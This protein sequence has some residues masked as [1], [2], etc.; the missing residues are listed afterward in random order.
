MRVI[1]AE[2]V[3]ALGWAAAIDAIRAAIVS[4]SA[5]PACRRARSSTYEPGSCS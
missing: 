1:D 5:P 4:D 2:A 3:A